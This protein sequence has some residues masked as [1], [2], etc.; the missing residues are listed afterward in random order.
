MK[1]D[2]VPWNIKA[3]FLEMIPR[4]V[5]LLMCMFSLNTYEMEN[6]DK[7]LFNP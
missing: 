2:K 5:A 4:Y 7:A 6:W 3:T 1:K